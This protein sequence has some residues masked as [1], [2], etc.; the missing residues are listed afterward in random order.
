MLLTT[1]VGLVSPLDELTADL[2]FSVNTLLF[3]SADFVSVTLFLLLEST[4]LTP[5]LE[6][7]R[8]V[9]LSAAAPFTVLSLALLFRATVLP[10]ASAVEV[11][12]VPSF[13]RK[14]F[15]PVDLLFPY[16]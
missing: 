16:W 11:L 7:L 9:K 10:G 12:L 15:V 1:F 8:R 6:L 3:V 5:E 13:S 4:L 2:L 14:T